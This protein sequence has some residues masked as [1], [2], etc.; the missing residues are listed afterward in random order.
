MRPWF[1]KSC[2]WHRSAAVDELRALLGQ[3]APL[4]LVIY[5]SICAWCA[6]GNV[7]SIPAPSVDREARTW[8]ANAALGRRLVGALVDVGLLLQEGDGY[9]I[10]AAIVQRPEG[11]EGEQAPVSRRQRP[12][13]E[14]RS[15]RYRETH[16]EEVRAKDRQRKASRKGSGKAGAGARVAES[17]R[18]ATDSATDS[19]TFHDAV[20]RRSAT[21]STTPFHDAPRHSATFR[22]APSPPDPPPTPAQAQAQAQAPEGAPAAAPA[23]PGVVVETPETKP[24]KPSAKPK[25]AP[26]RTLPAR[27]LLAAAYAAGVSQATRAP[28]SAP[29]ERWELDALE[30]MATTHAAGRLGAELLGWL[31][32]LGRDFASA[33]A[34]DAFLA[35]KGFAPKLALSWLNGGAEGRPA[36]QAPP[37][38]IPRIS[39][40]PLRPRPPGPSE[41]S[42]AVPPV[43]AAQALA[44]ALAELGDG[45]DADA[46]PSLQAPAAPPRRA[47]PPL[48]PSSLSPADQAELIA[49]GRAQLNAC[50]SLDPSLPQPQEPTA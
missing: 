45:F 2:D 35:S 39:P 12:P 27:A 20:P 36:P 3:Q 41:T 28:C 43:P 16:L 19:T 31:T 6:E 49:K 24:S 25:K 13:L 22:D 7:C 37:P 17:D 40:H 26:K 30:A 18:S 42:P 15:E 32:D 47:L 11:S 21:D 29:T 46:A 9:A 48:A 1:K 44:E 4:A 8:T 38:P 14:T 33:K 5:D 34:G 23:P 10:D 50:R